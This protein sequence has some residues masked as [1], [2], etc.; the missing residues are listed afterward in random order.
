MEDRSTEQ[1]GEDL[2]RL[3]AQIASA[4]CRWLQLLAEFDRRAGWS[5][6]GARSCAQWVGW[7]CAL[8]PGT[9]REYVRVATALERLPR[10]TALFARGELSYSKVRA[11][12]RLADV[13]REDELLAIVKD[14]TASQLERVVRGYRSVARLEEDAVRTHARR[15]L[16]VRSE[17]DGSIRINGRLTADEGAVLL[18][19][20]DR[21]REELWS[22]AAEDPVGSAVKRHVAATEPADAADERHDPGD[23]RAAG[24]ADAMVLLADTALASPALSG[25]SAPERHQVVLHVDADSLE[26]RLAGG[27]VLAP[28]VVRRLCC[29]ATLVAAVD[30]AGR[31]L[32]VGRRTRAI[33]PALRRALQARDGGCR[34]PGCRATR[35]LDAHHVE[36]WADGGATAADNLVSLCRHHHRAIHERGFAVVVGEAGEPEFRRPDGSPIAPH[37]VGP[38]VE[39][40]TR[41]RRRGVSAG[42][43]ATGSNQRYDRGAAVSAVLRMAPP[44]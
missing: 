9:A 15:F 23:V 35:L 4:L 37:P 33:P 43:L 32:D 24:Y 12:S 25:R 31:T 40:R 26:G 19:A 22:Q 7:R 8:S 29:D 27:E 16:H 41:L 10:T 18:A 6:A 30:R 42:T 11:I 39:G 34:F 21:G 28:S 3:S 20:L 5:D 13:T 44:G 1:L 2:A 38:C 17:E 36:H 14:A